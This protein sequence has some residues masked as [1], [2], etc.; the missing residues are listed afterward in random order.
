MALDI[1][2]DHTAW[3]RGE[4]WV[5]YAFT[6]IPEDHN[7]VGRRFLSAQSTRGTRKITCRTSTW[8][9]RRIGRR[10]RCQ[11]YRGARNIRAGKQGGGLQ[12]I[13]QRCYHRVEHSAVQERL[14]GQ[15][16]RDHAM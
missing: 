15:R 16:R 1:I 8:T 10:Y 3:A 14:C 13:R 7:R 12:G 6:M 11:Q 4:A 2:L 9:V 5:V